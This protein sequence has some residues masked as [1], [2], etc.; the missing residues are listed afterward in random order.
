[1]VIR[2]KSIATVVSALRERVSSVMSRSVDRTV[3]SLMVRIRVVLPAENGPVTTI[4]TAVPSAAA[5]ARSGRHHSPRTPAIRRSSRLLLMPGRGRTARRV[6]ARAAGRGA[7]TAPTGRRGGAVERRSCARAWR[8][9]RRAGRGERL[10]RWVRRTA[11]G[12]LRPDDAGRRA[13]TSGAVG[14]GG[15][16]GRG[17]PRGR[18][19]A[20]WRRSSAEAPSARRRGPASRPRLD[21]RG[22]RPDD[23]EVAAAGQRDEV[24]DRAPAVHELSSCHSSRVS[25]GRLRRRRGDRDHGVRRRDDGGRARPRRRAGGGPPRP[26]RRPAALAP[27]S[28]GSGSSTTNANSPSASAAGRRPRR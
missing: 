6:D 18:R 1:M 17:G 13:R 27:R 14:P 9:V 5:A 8:G 22:E 24:G 19:A 11:P 28:S 15:S 12:G 20:C 25:D 21:Q 10:G 26:P 4:L 7:G 3:I 23:R 16:A 2:P